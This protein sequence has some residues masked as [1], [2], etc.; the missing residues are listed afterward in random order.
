MALKNKWT[1]IAIVA[2]ILLALGGLSFGAYVGG[3][4][5]TNL[6]PL[7]HNYDEVYSLGNYSY[8]VGDD[9]LFKVLKIN[10]THLFS[11]ETEKDKKTLDG[12]EKTIAKE[13]PDLIVLLGD[14]VDGFNLSLSYDKKRA[15]DK[16]ATILENYGAPWT[17]I[18][19]NNEGEVDGNTKEVIAYL[20]G[21]EHF[22]SGNLVGIY[23]DV[24]FTIDLTQ[25]GE[26][27]HLLGFMDSGA[28]RPEVTGAYDHFRANQVEHM[29]AV[30]QTKSVPTS[31][32]FHMQTPKFERAYQNGEQLENMPIRYSQN[33]DTIPKNDIFDKL[34]EDESAI[35]L[36]SVG[37]QHGN[38]LCAYFEG[39]YYELASPSGYSAWRPEGVNP[40][41][42]TITINVEEDLAEN[43][44]RFEKIEI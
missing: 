35:K 18:P 26:V 21:Y 7:E 11:G 41:V 12:I 2:I 3:R 14:I 29:L 5:W 42:T 8:D 25:N 17:L 24:Q 27:K 6:L 22:T 31:L 44:Y 16:V 39:R 33:F 37:H 10:D 36:L 15:L 28:R 20:L 43:I 13:S 9:G 19:G 23:G 34:I 1:K 30:I 38:S 4:V 32:F 40:S